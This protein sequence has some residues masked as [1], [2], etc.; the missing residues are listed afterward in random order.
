M[1]AQVL[2]KRR[3]QSMKIINMSDRK[4]CRC[5]FCGTQKSVKYIVKVFDTG[6]QNPPT[7]VYAC[8][9]C[10]LLFEK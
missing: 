4:N 7:E 2:H 6:F 3:K 5:Y 9:R 10:A 8:N 1:I